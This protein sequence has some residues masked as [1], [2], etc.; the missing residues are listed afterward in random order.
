ME[1]KA[2]CVGETVLDII[3]KDGVPLCANPG[4]SAFNSA[5]SLGRAGTD[6]YFIGECGGDEAGRMIRDFLTENGVHPDC[7]REYPACKSTVSLAFLDGAN[8]AH[9]SF[10]RDEPSAHQDFIIPDIHAEDVLVFG[11]YFAVAPSLRAQIRRL[12][13]TAREAGAIIYYDV[14]FRPSHA[15]DLDSLKPAIE[16]NIAAADVVRASADDLHTV[17]GDS[18]VRPSCRCF[19]RTDGANEVSLFLDGRERKYAVEPLQPVS[20]IG[21]GDSFNAGVAC[22]LIKSGIMRSGLL[23][24]VWD[25]VMATA[26]AFAR[27]CCLSKENYIARDFSVS[28]TRCLKV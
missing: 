5:I 23:E 16:D 13:S 15:R 17:Y 1:R 21:A 28:L 18:S 10:Y 11:S 4:G 19:I 25:P 7:L 14:N 20:T 3:L 9:Y 12:L 24:E 2:I 26:L 22:G 8:D 27:N 6:S